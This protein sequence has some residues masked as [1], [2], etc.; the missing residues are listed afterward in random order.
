M[1]DAMRI[2]APGRGAPSW[3]TLPEIDPTALAGPGVAMTTLPADS[4]V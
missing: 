4:G 1:G 3:E 2:V